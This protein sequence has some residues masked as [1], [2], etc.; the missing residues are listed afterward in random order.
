MKSAEITGE[1][2][3]QLNDISESK[4]DYNCFIN[5]IKATTLSWYDMI[6][7]SNVTGYISENEK[8]MICPLCGKPVK[9]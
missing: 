1:W 7:K 2:E 6:A 4:L 5:S 8:K 9:N 3:K